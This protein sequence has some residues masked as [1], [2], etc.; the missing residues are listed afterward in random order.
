MTD[1]SAVAKGEVPPAARIFA[2]RCAAAGE[3][4]PES[5]GAN[6]FV[7]VV[8]AFPPYRQLNSQLEIHIGTLV[9]SAQVALL[10]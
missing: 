8:I 7:N 5:P 6:L 2:T 1:E 3:S 9:I 10:V 4:S